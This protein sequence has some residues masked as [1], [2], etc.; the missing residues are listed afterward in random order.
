[1]NQQLV[2][3]KKAHAKLSASGSE[4]WMECPG[5]PALSEKAP[6]SRE[7]E[8]AK[9]GTDAHSCLEVIMKNHGEKPFSAARLLKGKYP[10]EM[11]EHALKAYQEI[12]AR[13]PKGAK[14]IA[15]TKV[16]LTFV[17]PDMFGTVDA[18]IV[19]E[20]GR[21]WVI[22]Y[23]YGAGVPVDPEH[24]TQLIY[25]ALGLAHKYHYNFIDVS[26]VIIQPRAEHE[27]G[28]IREWVI[29]IEELMSWTE[30]FKKAVARTQDPLAEF[31]PNPKW[32]RWC[33]AAPIC[34]AIGE[35]SLKE[36]QADF[37]DD[38]GLTALPAVPS[39][40][41]PNLPVILTACDKLETWI[42]K[43]REHAHFA[44]ERGEKIPGFKL[45]QKRSIRKW[46]DEEKVAIAALKKFGQA[47]THTKPELLS[48]AQFEKSLP[49][50]KKFVNANTSNVSSGTTVVPES[51][52]RPAVSLIE[53]EFDVIS[54]GQMGEVKAIE[55]TTRVGSVSKTVRT[56]FKTVKGRWTSQDAQIQSLPKE[57]GDVATKKASKKPAKKSATKKTVKSKKA[58]K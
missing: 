23:K 48:P 45:V 10:D 28:P 37:D 38:L 15:E 42:E 34:P 14:L 11:I 2:S 29:S 24:N 57:G 3:E 36:A 39:I 33:K 22:D 27:R 55:T 44:L 5:E 50:Q 47:Y 25:Y 56:E 18:A 53:E 12:A 54:P 51:D 49:E 26:L 6:P 20:F 43:V 46:I 1:M 52:K 7:S 58:R 13:I 30:K 8:Y 17:G 4:R 41:I 32:C 19:E 31:N 9:E 35:R 40:Q 21:L 16:D